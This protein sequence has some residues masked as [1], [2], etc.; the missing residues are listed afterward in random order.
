M[1]TYLRVGRDTLL[2]HNIRKISVQPQGDDVYA[3][4]IN[5]SYPS[6]EGSKELCNGVRDNI[7][8]LLRGETQSIVLNMGDDLPVDLLDEYQHS[9]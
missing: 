3:L 8:D 4:R 2:A 9:Q 7:L 6:L 1:A 5:N